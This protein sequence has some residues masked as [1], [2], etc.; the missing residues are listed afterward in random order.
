VNQQ[1]LRRKVL[2]DCGASDSEI[3]E[4]LAYNHNVFDFSSVKL[5]QTF[6]PEP[7]PGVAAWEKYAAAAETAGVYEVLKKCLIQFQFPILA[8]ISETKE[9]RAAIRKGK[10]PHKSAIAIPLTFTE[11]E[12]LQIQLY[13][14]LAGTIPVLIAGNREDFVILVQALTKRNEPQPIPNSIGACTISGYNNWNR[15]NQYKEQWSVQQYKYSETDWEAEFKHLISRKELY[16]DRLILLD[17][18]PYSNV[19][20]SNLGLTEAKWQQLSIKIRLEHEFTHYFTRRFF[21]SMRN[22]MIDELIADYRGIVAALGYYRSDWFLHFIG[23]ES[24]PA[25]RKG[26]R[27]EN[28]RGEPVLSESAFK[29]LQIL[30][31][32]AAE[33]LARFDKQFCQLQRTPLEQV[34]ALVTLAALTLEE[35][36]N[37]YPKFLK[38]SHCC[39]LFY[40]KMMFK[41]RI[42]CC[43]AI[44][45]TTKKGYDRSFDSTVE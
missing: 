11:P 34:S 30:V 28:Y 40:G 10:L 4:L 41:Q 22:N 44:P 23:L 12:K 9:Y 27:L 3:A 16:Q 8:G 33:N 1:Q 32:K 45:K 13:Q 17:T 20:A 29:I 37:D 25:Y 31:K 2:V 15:I 6:P 43:K 39:E 19:T 21:G 18:G 7:E 24:F 42:S 38:V 36:A 35:L 26:A 14:T 5:P